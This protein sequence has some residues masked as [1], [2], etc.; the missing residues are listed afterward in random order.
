MS[1]IILNKNIKVK[2]VKQ[3][4]N[5]IMPF[6]FETEL[7]IAPLWLPQSIKSL[8]PIKEGRGPGWGKSVKR[9]QWKYRHFI[10]RAE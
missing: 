9:S 2:S 4:K 3:I 5:V 1:R 8:I 7:I 6:Q 10:Y